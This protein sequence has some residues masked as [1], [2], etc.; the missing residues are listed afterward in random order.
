MHLSKNLLD[1]VN[2]VLWIIALFFRFLGYTDFSFLVSILLLGIFVYRRNLSFGI[3]KVEDKFSRI[4]ITGVCI[5]SLLLS[6]PTVKLEKS[7]FQKRV[8]WPTFWHTIAITLCLLGYIFLFLIWRH[9]FRTKLDA[10][11]ISENKMK[12]YEIAGSILYT[13]ACIFSLGGKDLI[14]ISVL[15]TFWDPLKRAVRGVFETFSK[16]VLTFSKKR[17][18]AHLGAKKLLNIFNVLVDA[19]ESLVKRVVVRVSKA[20]QEPWDRIQEASRDPQLAWLFAIS[21]F[22]LA[23]LTFN[24]RLWWHFHGVVQT[25]VVGISFVFSYLSWHGFERGWKSKKFQVIVIALF[26]LLAIIWYVNPGSSPF[27]FG[28]TILTRVYDSAKFGGPLFSEPIIRGDVSSMRFPLTI[29]IIILIYFPILTYIESRIGQAISS[30]PKRLSDYKKWRTYSCI[31]T[32]LFLV[33]IQLLLLLFILFHPKFT[34]FVTIRLFLFLSLTGIFVLPFLPFIFQ[35]RELYMDDIGEDFDEQSIKCTFPE[36]FRPKVVSSIVTKNL[37]IGITV[38]C[39][40]WWLSIIV[41][42]ITHGSVSLIRAFIYLTQYRSLYIWLG[43]SSTLCGFISGLIA[44][45][46]VVKRSIVGGLKVGIYTGVISIVITLF[47]ILSRIATIG[48]LS[49]IYMLVTR[50]ASVTFPLF[51]W[52]FC[53]GGMISGALRIKHAYLFYAR[54]PTKLIEENHLC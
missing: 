15:L 46:G 35:G 31:S 28:L 1:I 23:N 5:G 17:P 9:F 2:F 4:L 19:A 13:F 6:W 25:L 48:D 20:K 27:F 37:L 34:P 32:A 21:V 7:F 22:A 51:I 49:S 54:A 47:F 36:W 30:T 16:K 18:G 50:L 29:W 39:L 38:G 45:R 11:R 44:L 42:S 26:I 8:F 53:V 52:S 41:G 14:L 24:F 43:F 10:H 3:L 12:Q 40:L 33:T